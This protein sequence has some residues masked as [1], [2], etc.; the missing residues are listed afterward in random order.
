M[1]GP[2]SP[3]PRSVLGRWGLEWLR[4][5]AAAAGRTALLAGMSIEILRTAAHFRNLPEETLARLARGFIERRL[6]AGE[7]LYAKGEPVD[8]LFVVAEG[9]LVVYRGREGEDVRPVAR[10]CG[11][12]LVGM[13]DLFDRDRHSETASALEESV[14]LQIARGELLEF[15]E[16]QPQVALNLRLAAARDLTARARLALE[17]ARRREARHRINRRVRV[18]PRDRG[19]VYAT[20][21]DVSPSGMSLRGGPESWQPEAVVRYRLHWGRRRLAMTGRVAWREGDYLGIE[22]QDTAPELQAELE[23]MVG[24]MLRSQI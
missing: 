9:M 13:A 10:L 15:L 3:G 2:V 17:V 4:L 23:Q 16:S 21:V 12:D 11:G 22:L 24:E 18:E 5:G 14:I 7:T 1:G 19:A 8:A 20:L 6:G